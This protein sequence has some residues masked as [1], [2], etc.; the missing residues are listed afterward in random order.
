MWLKLIG[1]NTSWF[2]WTRYSKQWYCMQVERA[3]SVY[4]CLLQL[5]V[6]SEELIIYHISYISTCPFKSA[7]S[8]WKSR[9]ERRF[10][11]ISLINWGR[12]LHAIVQNHVEQSTTFLSRLFIQFD[13]LCK[14]Y[15]IEELNKNKSRS[16]VV[17]RDVF[18]WLGFSLG[19]VLVDSFFRRVECGH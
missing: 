17:S 15:C 8:G 1:P 6:L 13:S 16:C 11:C 5:V 7:E 19:K 9:Y 12:K 2:L 14:D 10:D 4:V 18:A 3:L